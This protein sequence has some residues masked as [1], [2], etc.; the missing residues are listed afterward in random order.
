[1]S[2]EPISDAKRPKE[3]AILLLAKG[4]DPPRERARDQQA[5]RFGAQLRIE[6]L[7]ELVNQDPEPDGCADSLARIVA[8]WPEPTGPARA[9]ALSILAE[10][11][12]TRDNP[13]A[14]EWLLTE[15]LDGMQKRYRD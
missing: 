14:W 1:V 11:E 9:V 10:W 3:F 12:E 5:D 2:D 7:H 13:K 4:G 6:I 8:A 15:A